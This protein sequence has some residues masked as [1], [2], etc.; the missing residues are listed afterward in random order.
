MSRTMKQYSTLS[1]RYTQKNRLN[2]F[3]P[4]YYSRSKASEVVAEPLTEQL[5]RFFCIS[6]TN[7]QNIVNS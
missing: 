5:D 7:Y 1:D 4:I 2:V 3:C 6:Q